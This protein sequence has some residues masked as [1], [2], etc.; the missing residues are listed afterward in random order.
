MAIRKANH[1]ITE[2]RDAGKCFV[3][4]EMNS[5]QGEWWAIRALLA[6]GKNGVDMPD[7]IQGMGM[8]ALASAGL[9]ALF[10]ISPEEAK[11]L[12]DE[13]WAACVKIMPDPSKPHIIRDTI[14]QDVED[15]QTRFILRWEAIKLH[16]DFS[17]PAA[18]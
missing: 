16:M 9:K 8:A 11:P 6:I 12:F 18:P 2:G 14:P 17:T 1:T 7:G 10:K 4:T 15:I 3:L 5:E 13:L